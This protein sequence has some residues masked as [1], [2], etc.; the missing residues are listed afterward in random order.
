MPRKPVS[1]RYDLIPPL[2]LKAAAEVMHEGAAKYPDQPW[3][4]YRAEGGDETPINHAAAHLYKALTMEPGTAERRRQ[5]AKAAIGLLMQI[6]IEQRRS[7]SSPVIAFP[8]KNEKPKTE[9]ENTVH[10]SRGQ[11][12]DGIRRPLDPPTT[13]R[14]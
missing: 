3:L 4:S 10:V 7:D 5:L 6:D 11:Y 8:L 1:Y 14:S 12:I 9:K 2:G 13:Y